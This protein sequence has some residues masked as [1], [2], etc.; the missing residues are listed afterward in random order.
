MDEVERLSNNLRAKNA[1]I[2]PGRC[3]TPPKPDPVMDAIFIEVEKERAK[4]KLNNGIVQSVEYKLI[5][6]TKK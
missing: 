5:E 2:P 6:D 1:V 4:M 3:D